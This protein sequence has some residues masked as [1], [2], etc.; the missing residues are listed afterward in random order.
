MTRC[1]WLDEKGGFFSFAR[2]KVDIPAMLMASQGQKMA[3]MFHNAGV[4]KSLISSLEHRASSF[5]GRLHARND[6][7]KPFIP[8]RA[9]GVLGLLS[10]RIR[11]T[12]LGF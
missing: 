12:A 10:T 9:T 11:I 6:S 5:G 7:I 1:A 8:V 4:I 3:A 2:H